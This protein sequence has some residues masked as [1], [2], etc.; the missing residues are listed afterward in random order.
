MTLENKTFEELLGDFNPVEEL[1]KLYY[2]T[3]DKRI[4]LDICTELMKYNYSLP[5]EE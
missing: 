3:D 4:K 1:V 2:Q 5:Q